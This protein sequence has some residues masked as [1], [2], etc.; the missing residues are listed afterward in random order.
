ML[1]IIYLLVCYAPVRKHHKLLSTM[2]QRNDHEYCPLLRKRHSQKQMANRER[3]RVKYE[4][5]QGRNGLVTLNIQ[6]WRYRLF[7]F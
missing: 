3:E 5:V 1:I 4:E 2:S 7:F 6:Y